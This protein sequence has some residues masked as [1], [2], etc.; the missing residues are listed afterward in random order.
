MFIVDPA[1]RRRLPV[2]LSALT[3]LLPSTSALF[4]LSRLGTSF[5]FNHFRTLLHEYENN[6]LEPPVFAYSCALFAKSDFLT[7]FF[8]CSS[9]LFA[10]TWGVGGRQVFFSN[11]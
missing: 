6:Q 1:P 4:S 8:P 11:R 7:P 10:N 5:A 9:A 2:H 3:P